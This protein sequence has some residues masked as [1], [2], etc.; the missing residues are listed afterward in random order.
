MVPVEISYHGC[1]SNCTTCAQQPGDTTTGLDSFNIKIGLG[2]SA[3]GQFTGSLQLYSKYPSTNLALPS[4][5]V[6]VINNS[7]TNLNS[8][9]TNQILGPQG[10]CVIP[11]P[12]SYYQYD[13]YF[14]SNN[15]VG[16][17]SG[18][19]YTVTNG[20]HYKQITIQNPDTSNSFNRLSITEIQAGITNQTTYAYTNVNGTNDLWTYTTY[21]G[22]HKETLSASVDTAGETWHNRY[23]TRTILRPSD[24]AVIYQEA[25]V[26]SNW[27]NLNND[28]PSQKIV[29]PT[30]A[31]LI[32]TYTYYTD[33]SAANRLGQLQEQIDPDGK[34]QKFD[35]ADD[36]RIATNTTGFLNNS[37]STS[38]AS[39]RTIV[40][41]YS[42]NA[43][44]VTI[45]EKLLDQEV[46]RK[47]TVYTNNETDE[48]Q[49]Q[50]P[51][52][53]YTASDNLVT[54]TIYS[55]ASDWSQNQPISVSHPDGTMTFY[56]YATNG[57]TLTTTT[58]TGQPNG[59]HTAI[60]EGTK[61]IEVKGFSGQ[62]ISNIVMNVTGG[63]AGAVVSQTTYTYDASDA[64]YRSPTMTYLD[65]TTTS[66]RF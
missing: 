21:N 10:L 15:S 26:Y 24:D 31:N 63:S 12:A 61:T 1:D 65:G 38:D 27:P 53:A 59:G 62:M 56:S 54:K 17:F 58:T 19:L 18:G 49:C 23:E 55:T 9:W 64:F 28:L 34:W 29:D 6:P 40:T 20:T 42:T 25:M 43:P 36:G 33:P 30:G 52:A 45:I 39:N 16:P 3:Y 41:I 46:S 51:G 4:Q 32:T 35:Y 57:A 60:D 5:L 66:I 2:K 13:I 7:F 50:T 22:L 14:Y 11:S 48:Y 8:G 47:Y 44:Q 37:D